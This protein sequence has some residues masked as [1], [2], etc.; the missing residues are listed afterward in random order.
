LSITLAQDFTAIGANFSLIFHPA[1]NNA[2]S[3]FLKEFS[4]NN[5]I[6]ISQKGVC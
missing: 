4:S 5:S 3:I 1:E 2:K 6:F